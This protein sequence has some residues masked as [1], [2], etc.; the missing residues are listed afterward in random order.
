MKAIPRIISA[1]GLFVLFSCQPDKTM[2]DASGTFEATE[3]IVSSS[4]NGQIM[5]FKVREGEKIEKDQWVGYMDS[6]PFYLK[7]KQLYQNIKSLESRKPEIDKQIAVIQTQ[8]NTQ[9]REKQRVENL[10]QVRAANQ[11]QLDDINAQIAW[12]ETQLEAQK[13]SLEITWNGIREDISSLEI[14]I[15]QLNDQLNKCQIVNPISGTVLVKYAEQSELAIPGKVLYK[16][17]DLG[18]MVFRA[19]ITSDQLTQLQ[20]GQEVKVFADFGEETR[21]YP[22]RVQWISEK[23]EFTPKTIQ[24]RDER[25]N[26][27]YAMKISVKNDGFIKIGMYG[28]VKF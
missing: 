18:N 16:I 11:K 6:I 21:E 28:Q 8:I 27:V 19:Y 20:I 25:A 14:Q 13:S 5:A 2:Y 17:A 9:Y 12:L 26:L 23:S 10:I 15:E 24:T 22:G 3:I 1:A 7:K 4:V